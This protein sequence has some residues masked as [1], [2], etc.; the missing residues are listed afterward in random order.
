MIGFCVSFALMA[1]AFGP[2][3][4][5]VNQTPDRIPADVIAEEQERAES[6][7]GAVNAGLVSGGGFILYV[8]T[9]QVLLLPCSEVTKPHI[10]KS[11]KYSTLKSFVSMLFTGLNP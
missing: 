6:K 3:L 4:M 5:L 7:V 10:Q 9:Q 8:S 11:Q 2:M 1:L